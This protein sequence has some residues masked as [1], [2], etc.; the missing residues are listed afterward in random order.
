MATVHD[1]AAYIL[2]KQGPITTMKLHKL[3]YY[4]QAWSLVWDDER[5]FRDR[6]EAW[7][8]G[9]V[10]PAVYRMH[11]GQF[12]VHTWS[13]G[14]SSALNEQQEETVDAILEYYGDKSSQWLSDLTHEE[15][16]WKNARAGLAS[17]DR[18]SQQIT[19]SSMAEYYSSL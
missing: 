2:E 13:H 5:L 10:I 14:N 1:V 17:S 9:P 3:L 19:L 11:R 6:V 7:A 15:D 16:P 8:N 18:G 12:K 4:S